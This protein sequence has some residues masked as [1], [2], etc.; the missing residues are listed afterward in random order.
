MVRVALIGTGS[1]AVQNHI[2]G[3][4]LHPQG[5]V[6]ALCDPDPRALAAAS[7]AVGV[8]RTY[9]D[10]ASL[11]RQDDVD[12]VVI[13]TPNHVHKPIAEAAM[14]AGK[15]VLCEKP[16]GLDYAETESMRLAAERARVVHMTAFTYRF[17][18][19]IRWMKALIAEGAIGTPYH[20]RIQRLQDWGD[21]ALGWRQHKALCG[22]GELGDMLAHRIDYAHFLLGPIARLV[23]QTRQ[24]LPERRTPDGR[25]DASDVDDWVAVIGEMADGATAVFES[26]KMATGRGSGAESIDSVEIN[27]S[28]A[29]LVYTLE[30]PHALSIGRPGG[31]H[32]DSVPVPASFLRIPAS[33]RDPQAHD[34]RQGFRYDQGVEFVDA[35]ATGRSASPDFVDGSRAQAV[36]DAILRSAEQRQWVDIPAWT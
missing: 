21:R 2:P 12:A 27:G 17:I 6:V 7:V 16:L 31:T 5:Q 34:P 32:L 29:T 9:A 13:A 19:A 3:I 24:V 23:A 36:M 20:V 4:R 33:P 26:T 14:A 18:P 1:I 35:I 15:H 8:D 25:V 30:N 11:L 10:Y 22:S 28:D